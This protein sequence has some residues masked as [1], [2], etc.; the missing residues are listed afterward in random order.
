MYLVLPTKY[1]SVND[2]RY[3]LFLKT[4]KTA[5]NHIMIEK[6]IIVDTSEQDVYEQIKFLE[7]SSNSR[8]VV[9]YSEDPDSKK[10]GS[11]R[12]GIRYAMKELKPNIIA[13]QEPEKDSMIYHYDGILKEMRNF[14][15]CVCV[16]KRLGISFDSYP[17][18]QYHSEK[19][20]NMYLS[21]LTGLDVD[22]SFGPIVLTPNLAHHWT[23]YDGVLWDAQIVPLYDIYK[24]G[25]DI[26]NYKVPF[27]YPVEQKN[28]EENNLDFIEKRRFQLNY[29]I[30][31][32]KKRI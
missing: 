5:L 31:A 17:V 8:I 19:Y 22:W 1:T 6:I 9:L 27:R 14:N 26:I 20:L 32:I 10:G 4:L 25:G 12:Q 28:K 30:D 24:T 21:K 13:F 23:M 7:K 15:K 18:E 16:P 11:I 29:M 3:S 2:L